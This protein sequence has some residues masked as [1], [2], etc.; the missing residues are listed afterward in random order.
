Q[1]FSF[2]DGHRLSL[3]GTVASDQIT[4]I[5]DFYDALRKS[6]LNGQAMFNADGGEQ[7]TY[8]QSGSQATWSFSLELRRTEEVE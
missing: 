5:T 8:H 7:L 6:K 2:G 4:L 1:R 3:N